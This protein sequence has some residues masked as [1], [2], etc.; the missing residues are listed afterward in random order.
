VD[1]SVDDV[2][3]SLEIFGFRASCLDTSPIYLGYG[4]EARRRGSN[5]HNRLSISM[6]CQSSISKRFSSHFC[7]ILHTRSASVRI[8][9]SV[10]NAI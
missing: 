7:E 5:H 6:F 10:M 9:L 3:L 4:A 2:L 1:A 8:S